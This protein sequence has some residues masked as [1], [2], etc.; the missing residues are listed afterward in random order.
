MTHPYHP[1]AGQELEW[2]DEHGHGGERWL[3]LRDEHRRMHSVL[4]RW[5]SVVDD[6]PLVRMGAGRAHLRA[7]DL[8]RLAELVARYAGAAGPG[9]SDV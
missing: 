3:E 6:E 1:L 2:I 4:A 7:D 8:V 5:T 9:R